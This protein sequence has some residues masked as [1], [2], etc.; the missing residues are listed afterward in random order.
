MTSS[1]I[2]FKKH[3]YIEELHNQAVTNSRMINKAGCLWLQHKYSM[4][5]YTYPFLITVQANALLL[6]S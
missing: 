5:L 1:D 3:S 4:K 6:I 2:I